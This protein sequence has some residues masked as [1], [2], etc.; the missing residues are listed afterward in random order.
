MNEYRILVGKSEGKIP[1]GRARRRL[2]DNI[3]MEIKVIEW[4]VMNW[5]DLAQDED[6]WRALLKTVMNLRVP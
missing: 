4:G 3:K 5:I 6:Q 2:V 1:L